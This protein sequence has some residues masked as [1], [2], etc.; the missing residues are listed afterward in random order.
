M[1]HCRFLYWGSNSSW[2]E[3]PGSR[4]SSRLP[5]PEWLPRATLGPVSGSKKMTSW[6][7]DFYRTDVISKNSA[8]MAKCSQILN[9]PNEPRMF[10]T[11][12]FLF[13]KHLKVSLPAVVLPAA[14]GIFPVGSF[15]RLEEAPE[16]TLHVSVGRV[17]SFSQVQWNVVRRRKHLFPGV[18][19][20][21]SFQRSSV[22]KGRSSFLGDLEIEPYYVCSFK[23]NQMSRHRGS[24][25]LSGGVL[26]PCRA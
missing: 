17:G 5:E 8:V 1:K 18:P 25:D 9:E 14:A 4:G 26:Y 12:K 13:Q 20:E 24:S 22:F 23:S 3:A 7:N 19:R 10:R 11:D 2:G 21:K 6:V 16:W 15:Q